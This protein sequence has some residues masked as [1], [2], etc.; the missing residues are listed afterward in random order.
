MQVGDL[1]NG[2][3]RLDLGQALIIAACGLP[4]GWIGAWGAIAAAVAVWAA[5]PAVPAGPATLFWAVP[6]I[7]VLA[8]LVGAL[9]RVSISRNLEGARRLGLGPGGL[10]L[11]WP[12][13]RLVGAV[14][15]CLIFWLMVASVL[16]LVVLAVAGLSELDSAA[17]Q[18]RNWA[19]VGPWWKLATLAIIGLGALYILTVVTVRL[20][21]WAPAT[22]GR[23][24][25]VS[26]NS[27]GI[28]QGSFWPLLAGLVLTAIPTGLLVALGA[29]GALK[30]WE[31]E[32]FGLIGLFGVQAPLTLAFLGRAYLEL[33]YWV[34][35]A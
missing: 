26:L 4:R 30:G 14:I 13:A 3:R 6:A 34:P 8:V 27:M 25:M 29:A 35:E 1:G 7:V 10:Q 32:V 15:L 18:A 19:A 5:R 9:A 22:L 17:I 20:T 33:E 31:G 24:H 21:L 16:A 28:A 12:E 2:R 23:G 11:A